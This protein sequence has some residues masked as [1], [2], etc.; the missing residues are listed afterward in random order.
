[1]DELEFA[2]YK[3]HKVACIQAA[4]LKAKEQIVSFTLPSGTINVTLTN[5]VL[6]S[7]EDRRDS[8]EASDYICDVTKTKKILG[9]EIQILIDNMNVKIKDME[10]YADSLVDTIN[11]ATTIQN[12]DNVVWNYNVH[13][14]S[15]NPVMS[16]V[17]YTKYSLSGNKT[18][19]ITHNKNKYP[20]INILV[21]GD[22]VY[23]DVKHINTN[24]LTVTFS[25]N[26]S[27]EVILE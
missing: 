13:A 11:S 19:S 1:M 12:V 18:Y 25:T 20:Q 7:Y 9:S 15:Y 16:Q 4:L 14:V 17:Y 21:G 6:T 5:N 10:V 3:S 24:T 27:C 8:I 26:T 2:M 23:A 22:L